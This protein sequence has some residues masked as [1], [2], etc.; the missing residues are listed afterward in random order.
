MTD[1][2]WDLP[3]SAATPEDRFHGRRRLLK[4]VGVTAALGGAGCL[5]WQWYKGSREEILRAGRAGTAVSADET[6]AIDWAALPEREFGTVRRPVTDIGAVGGYVNYYEFSPR[7]AGTWRSAQ[8]LTIDPWTLVID[9]LVENP[10][11]LDLDG[12]Y[13]TFPLEQ[14]VCRFRCVETWAMVVPWVG[15]PLRMLLERVRPLDSA[16]FVRFETCDTEALSGVAPPSGYRF[17]YREGL[18]I[19]EAANELAFCAVG[20]Y[21]EPIFKQ[22]GAPIRMVLPWK[23]GFKGAKSVVR[24]EFVKRRPRT[25]WNDSAP[26]EYG[27]YS[28]VNPERPHPRWSQRTEYLID[29]GE[30]FDTR[31]HNGY[32]PWVADLY[33]GNEY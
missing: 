4:T 3:E 9:G 13:R 31:I 7:K 26:G 24:M 25:F 23:Y 11:T 12:L 2:S 14:R 18:T 17:P 5:G 20:Y 19:A 1:R 33:T 29:T 30:R 8:N 21:G 6:A 16:G 27:F 15:F 32:G 10:L 22:N 28:N